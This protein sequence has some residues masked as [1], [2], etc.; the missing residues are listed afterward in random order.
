MDPKLPIKQGYTKFSEKMQQPYNL[1]KAWYPPPTSLTFVLCCTPRFPYSCIPHTPLA[2]NMCMR[3][4]WFLTS[5]CCWMTSSSCPHPPGAVHSLD[6]PEIPVRFPHCFPPPPD[7]EAAYA[8]PPPQP[9]QQ[10]R[11]KRVGKTQTQGDSLSGPGTPLFIVGQ[12]LGGGGNAIKDFG[13]W[14]W[15][16]RDEFASCEFQNAPLRC[17]AYQRENTQG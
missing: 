5:I 13:A 8:P 9:W 14:F 17:R 2:V 1:V 16:F 11:A 15:P 7:A 6:L 4:C 10:R 12:V 3:P